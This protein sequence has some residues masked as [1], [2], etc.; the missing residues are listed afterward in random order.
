MTHAASDDEG[1]VCAFQL[2]P[3][4]RRGLDVLKE[5]PDRPLWLHFNLN[6]G[7]ARRWIQD[8]S[9]V[10][11]AAR[12]LLLGPEPRI[13]TETLGDGFAAVL[14]DL[15]HDSNGEPEGMH[16]IRI[17]VDRQRIITTRKHPLMTSDRL[18]KELQSGQHEPQHPI[19]LFERFIEDLARTFGAVVSKLADQVDDAEEDILVGNFQHRGKALGRMRRSLARLRRHLAANR[20]ALSH[21]PG[22]L[23]S[24]FTHDQKH[25][26]RQAVE[27]LDAVAQDLELVQERARLLQEEIA[28]RLTE[29]TNRNLYVLSMV[30]TTLL[31]ITLVTGVFG[32]NVGGLP[33][34]TNSGGFWWVLSV[35]L[36]ALLTTLLVLRSRRIG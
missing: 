9:S 2:A 21:L 3:L 23:P 4:T 16:T 1:L 31:P 15:D 8:R 13:Q 28:A 30:T 10:P 11:D 35:M 27:S 24:S 20:S 17:Y 14:G 36:L 25:S 26:L 6:D 32:M 5:K 33:W 19:A 22:R 29:A 7:R 12:E 18:R 34:V